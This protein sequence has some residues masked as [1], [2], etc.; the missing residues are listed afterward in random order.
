MIC[1]NNS[2]N[3]KTFLNPSCINSKAERIITIYYG[4]DKDCEHDTHMVCKECCAAI[5]KDA[6]SHGYIVEI[7]NM[8]INIKVS[9]TQ[10]EEAE[11][12]GFFEVDCKNCHES[13]RVEPDI[14]DTICPYC[15]TKFHL[16]KPD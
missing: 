15:H 6:S 3:A 9:M 5:A 10:C 16:I 14:A 2:Q 7:E 4:K 13:F 11:S 1:Q 8:A 12:E